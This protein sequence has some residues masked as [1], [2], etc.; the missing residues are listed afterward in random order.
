MYRWD[1]PDLPHKGWLC[2]D[3]VDH[4]EPEFACEM[5]GNPEVRYEHVM[6]HPDVPGTIGAGCVCAGHMEE[7]DRAARERER[8]ARN[9]AARRARLQARHAQALAR[10][11]DPDAWRVSEKGN[12]WRKARG[13]RVTVFRDPRTPAAWR[14]AIGDR[15]G[16]RTYTTAEAAMRGVFDRLFPLR[17]LEGDLAAHGRSTLK[18]PGERGFR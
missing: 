8:V 1:R 10:W 13:V 15:F 3:L 16:T 4:E 12:Y 2:V 9:V 18:L 17:R 7:D 5:C 14:A 6:A 11:A